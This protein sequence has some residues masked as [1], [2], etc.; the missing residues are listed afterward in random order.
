[1]VFFSN[2][3]CI[4]LYNSGLTAGKV[5]KQYRIYYLLL[6]LILSH[7]DINIHTNTMV[8][9]YKKAGIHWKI[10]NIKLSNFSGYF[11]GA[12]SFEMFLRKRKIITKKLRVNSS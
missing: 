5:M 9:C 12:L 2:Q 4:H 3:T 10:F 8:E 1:M 11:F 7:R 6:F